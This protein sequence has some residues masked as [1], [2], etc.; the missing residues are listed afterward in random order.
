MIEYLNAQSLMSS[1]DEIQTFCVLVNRGFSPVFQIILST[2]TAIKFF[3]V[4][5]GV[6][7][8]H[9]FTLGMTYLPL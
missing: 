3:V 6:E 7:G 2:Y 1:M 4:M 8:E 5:V 9:V